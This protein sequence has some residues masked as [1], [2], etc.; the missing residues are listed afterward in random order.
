MTDIDLIPASYRESLRVQGWARYMLI[1]VSFVLVMSI[2]GYFTL[3]YMNNSLS[4]EISDLQSEQQISELQ[5]GVLTNLS[6]E[7][8]RFTNQLSFLTGLRSGTAAPEMFMTVDRALENKEVWFL[9]WEFRRAGTAVEKDEKTSS[10][11]YF[12]IIPATNG[13][14][15]A[16]TW[17]IET[18]MTIKGQAKDHSALSRFV[19]KL[20]NQPEIQN[21][22][23]LNTSRR[24]KARVVNFDLA[25][26]VNSRSETG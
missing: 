3:D 9:D 21:V 17:K 15:T 1:T 20:F 16:E 10:N 26:T 11:G 8:T 5:R 4:A 13:E 2:T 19:R 18:H 22:R 7:K 6:E 14:N 24:A 12:I 25:V 23:I